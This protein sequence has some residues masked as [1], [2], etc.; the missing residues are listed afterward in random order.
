MQGT[1]M[2]VATM[3]FPIRVETF[4]SGK[5]LLVFASTVI[6]DCASLGTLSILGAVRLFCVIN[7]VNIFPFY[8]AKTVERM[9]A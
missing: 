4:G 7:W 2:N 3:S 6:L 8:G 9:F 1:K 5:L